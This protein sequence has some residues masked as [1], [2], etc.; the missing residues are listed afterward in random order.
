MKEHQSTTHAPPVQLQNL[1]SKTIFRQFPFVLLELF[2]ELIQFYLGTSYPW[3]SIK[4]QFKD[5][6][7]PTLRLKLRK[8]IES[9]GSYS[10]LKDGP[11]RV[12]TNHLFLSNIN[13]ILFTS[14]LVYLIVGRKIC[15]YKF[16]KLHVNKYI[17][18]ILRI[19]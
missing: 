18:S 1:R 7:S 8:V 16:F 9:K 4:L 17:N 3:P 13:F 6:S 19:K 15:S 5:V 11:K 10:L 2:K 14:Y 12:C